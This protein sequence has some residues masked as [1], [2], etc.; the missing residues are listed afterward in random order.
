MT[1]KKGSTAAAAIAVMAF[2]AAPVTAQSS[3]LTGSDVFTIGVSPLSELGAG[4][5]NVGAMPEGSAG[6]LVPHDAKRPR[7]EGE[8]PTTVESLPLQQRVQFIRSV[9]DA[10]WYA[11]YIIEANETGPKVLDGTG[12]TFQIPWAGFYNHTKNDHGWTN[13]QIEGYFEEEGITP[14]EPYPASVQKLSLNQQIEFAKHSIEWFD[15][16][17]SSV[18][19]EAKTVTLRDGLGNSFDVGFGFFFTHTWA[20]HNWTNKL[21]QDW[22]NAQAMEQMVG[23]SR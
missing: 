9:G 3:A 12:R 10:G 22:R 14:T 7:I 23:S 5:S 1:W 13:E 20:A 4:E 18:D 17:I 21:V 19:G 16:F 15:H 6:W 8:Y 11:H 2:A